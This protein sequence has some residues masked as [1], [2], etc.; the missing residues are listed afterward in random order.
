MNK[1]CLFSGD[2]CEGMASSKEHVINNS[3]RIFI[4]NRGA[5]LGNTKARFRGITCSNCNSYLGSI[6]EKTYSGLAIATLWKVLAGNI[7]NAFERAPWAQI[8]YTDLITIKNTLDILRNAL[9]EA[10]VFPENMFG[11]NL[12]Y[13]GVSCVD[14]KF[15][16]SVLTDAESVTVFQDLIVVINSKSGEQ[17]DFRADFLL[18]HSH[19][20]NGHRLLFCLPLIPQVA[21]RW[22]NTSIEIKHKGFGKLAKE[23]LET[24]AGTTCEVYKFFDSA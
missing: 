21:T 1:P 16:M 4:K 2:N 13:S 20:S 11:Y 8:H 24:N 22:A 17:F 9:L 3:R 10:K 12:T 6:E 15:S 19:Q 14:G 18:Y 5:N 7:N 23:Y